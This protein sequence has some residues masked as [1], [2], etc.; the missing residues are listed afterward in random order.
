[1]WS[2]VEVNLESPLVDLQPELARAANMVPEA[3]SLLERPFLELLNLR[4]DV[5]SPAFATAI[6]AVL[7]AS[8]PAAPNTVAQGRDMLLLWLGPDEWLLQSVQA[9]QSLLEG[10]LRTILQGKFASVVDVSSGHAVLQL[11]GRHARTVLQK[12][13]PLDLHPRV[14]GLGQCAQSHYFRAGILLRVVAPDR[15]ELIVRRSFADYL[16]RMLLNAAEEFM[17]E[18]VS[19]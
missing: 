3:L 9:R 5:H 11:A 14:F 12:G 18:P 6:T 2:D 16:G 8:P 15:F 7:G 10:E 17:M 1:M 19:T 13:C 4:G